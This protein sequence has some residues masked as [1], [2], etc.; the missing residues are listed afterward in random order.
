MHLAILVTNTDNSA[1]AA[2]HPFDGEKFT[3]LVQMARPDWHTSVFQLNEGAFPQDISA[4]DGVIITG[5]PASSRSDLPWI[6]PLLVLIRAMDQAQLPLF[7]AC[8]GH[9]AIALARGGSVAQNPAGWVHGLIH[10]QITTPLPWA[11]DLPQDLRL[12]G[13]H[14]ECV[15]KIPPQAQEVAR[16]TELNAGFTIGRHIWTT[17][18]HPE[19]SPGFIAALTEEMHPSLGESLYRQAVNSLEEPADQAAFAT[20]L[21][22]FFEQA[23]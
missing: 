19:M 22:Q 23:K 11:P 5:S 18:R 7:G 17:Q 14:S 3:R 13:S 2:A 8:F 4:F 15:D 10:N 1:F 21:A 20:A 16:S 12:Y 9:Q 6:E